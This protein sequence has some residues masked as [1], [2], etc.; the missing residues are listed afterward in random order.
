MTY[1]VEGNLQDG[2]EVIKQSM[3]LTT[4]GTVQQVP[5]DG[6]ASGKFATI[7]KAFEASQ[8]RVKQAIDIHIDG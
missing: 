1:T 6:V 2:F 4:Q 3:R 5:I 8:E 7:Q